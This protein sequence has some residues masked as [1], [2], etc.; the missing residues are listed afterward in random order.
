MGHFYS[1]RVYNHREC[2]LTNLFSKVVSTFS[3]I[4]LSRSLTLDNTTPTP[5]FLTAHLLEGARG[6]SPP[7]L[8]ADHADDDADHGDNDA[9]HGYI[10]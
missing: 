5:L 10:K 6:R 3:R 9:D 1:S 8:A 7:S 4:A 2:V